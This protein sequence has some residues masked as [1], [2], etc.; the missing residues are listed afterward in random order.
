M[1]KVYHLRKKF[2]TDKREYLHIKIV[3]NANDILLISYKSCYKGHTDILRMD[4][5]EFKG[6]EVI[7]SN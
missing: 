1:I 3:E 4:T 6:D 2:M 7:L 5:K